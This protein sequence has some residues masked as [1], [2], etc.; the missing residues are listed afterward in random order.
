MAVADKVF[1]G[2][3]QCQKVRYRV[4]GDLG[5]MSHCHCTDCRKMH[6]AA[7]ATYVGVERK[8][9]KFLSGEDRL[10][11]F[12]AESGTERQFCRACGSSLTSGIASEP[13]MIYIA[14]GTFDT[15]IDRKPESHIFV[16][17]RVPWFDILD[18]RP[19]RQTY[20]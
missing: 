17:S 20:E 12:R 8:L 7:F 13:G 10:A 14:A 15:P 19:Q 5:E 16:R 6:G 4:T 2:S 3:C 18:G 1:E 9:F 11:S